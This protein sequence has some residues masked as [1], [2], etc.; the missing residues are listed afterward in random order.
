MA[1]VVDKTVKAYNI[2]S[3]T[4]AQLLHLYKV[5]GDSPADEEGHYLYKLLEEATQH[6]R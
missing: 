4:E 6:L 3:L 5:V 2:E 1:K